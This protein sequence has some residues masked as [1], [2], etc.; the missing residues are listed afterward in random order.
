MEQ[1]AVITG[2]AGGMGLAT[3]KILGRDH[4]VVIADLDQVRLDAAVAELAALGIDAGAAVCDITDRASVDA[5]LDRAEEGGHVRAVVHTAG[6]SPQMGSAAFII[7]VNAVG[8]VNLVE[9]YLRL[10]DE[11]DAIVNVASIAGHMSPGFLQPRRAF[12]LARTDLSKFARRLVANAHLLPKAA[13]PGSAYGTSKAFVIWYTRRM[14]ADFGA[15]GAR[16]VSVSP[17]T[18][19]TAMGRLE[20]ASGSGKLI[21]YAALKRY[22]QPNEVAEVLAFAAST[23]PGY[24]T[25]TDILVDGGTKAGLN[26]KGMIA[27]ARGD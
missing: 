1:T 10:A 16:I 2:G 13:R 18:F 12:D 24:L 21:E 7:R 8:T 22:G 9:S 5:L 14:A 23:K 4:R 6:V 15:R 11:G 19:D 20:E 25:G 26:L 17:G 3:A 27:I